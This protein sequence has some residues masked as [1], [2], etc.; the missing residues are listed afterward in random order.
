[1]K[2]FI[3]LPGFPCDRPL[4]NFSFFSTS[5]LS[6]RRHLLSPTASAIIGLPLAPSPR[7]LRRSDL[8]PLR[9]PKADFV[10]QQNPYVAGARHCEQDFRSQTGKGALAKREEL[11]SLSPVLLLLRTLISLLRRSC[12][13]S[14][15]CLLLARLAKPV[16]TIGG[17][18]TY[19]LSSHLI[20][21]HTSCREGVLNIELCHPCFLVFSSFFMALRFLLSVHPS[22]I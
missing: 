16:G 22:S 20:F 11:P 17:S 13:F 10:P 5:L 4:P 14:W 19:A 8:V 9:A 6:P 3:G 12:L 15:S 7:P 18:D 2:S 21:C 1:M